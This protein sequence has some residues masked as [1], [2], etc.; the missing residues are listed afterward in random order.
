MFL[1]ALPDFLAAFCWLFG[2][3]WQS[4]RA[5]QSSCVSASLYSQLVYLLLNVSSPSPWLLARWRH[6]LAKRFGVHRIVSRKFLPTL[7]LRRWFYLR[8]PNNKEMAQRL[9]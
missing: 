2:A 6:Y 1:H 9:V 4:F 8:V 5:S 3:F 7:L